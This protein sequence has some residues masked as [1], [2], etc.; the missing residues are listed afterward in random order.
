M[1]HAE[2]THR[3]HFKDTFYAGSTDTSEWKEFAFQKTTAAGQKAGVHVCTIM[4]KDDGGYWKNFPARPDRFDI[5][6]GPFAA[7][8]PE[9]WKLNLYTGQWEPN[10]N[11]CGECDECLALY[12]SELWKENA[13]Q[14]SKPS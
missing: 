4:D 1:E 14:R 9:E 3:K 2:R 11:E 6:T 12:P 10:C 13:A 7:E 8:R 5:K